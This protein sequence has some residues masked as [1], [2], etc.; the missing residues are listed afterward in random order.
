[1]N[2]EHTLRCVIVLLSQKLYKKIDS[3]AMIRFSRA[4]SFVD[5]Y[6]VKAVL[7]VDGFTAFKVLNF[8]QR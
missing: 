8:P 5:T 1:M 6:K 4:N 3:S 2:I 7:L